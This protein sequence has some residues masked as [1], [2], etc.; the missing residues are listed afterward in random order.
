M[1]RLERVVETRPKGPERQGYFNQEEGRYRKRNISEYFEPRWALLVRRTVVREESVG[2]FG[3]YTSGINDDLEN[4]LL[5]ASPCRRWKKGS[6][7]PV[8]LQLDA[9]VWTPRFPLFVSCILCICWRFL[10]LISAP[11][12]C[13]QE[14]KAGP[15]SPIGLQTLL[16]RRTELRRWR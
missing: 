1:G 9:N 12:A 8:I 6:N 11:A 16:S 15:P 3:E 5:S 10:G 2:Q 13:V 7:R 14:A 4:R